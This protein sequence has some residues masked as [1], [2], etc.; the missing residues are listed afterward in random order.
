[1]IIR[2]AMAIWSILKKLGRSWT[3]AQQARAEWEVHQHLKLRGYKD[4]SE[5]QKEKLKYYERSHF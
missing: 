2:V 4:L 5:Y 3:E 1:M